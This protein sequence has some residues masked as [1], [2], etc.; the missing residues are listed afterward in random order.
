MA[1]ISGM[2][3]RKLL[4]QRLPNGGSKFKRSRFNETAI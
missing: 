1:A 2:D 4:I 3:H